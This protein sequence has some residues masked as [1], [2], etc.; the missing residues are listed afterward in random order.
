MK[1]KLELE[2]DN[3]AFD[4]DPDAEVWDILRKASEKVLH[5]GIPVDAKYRLMDSN[6]NTVGFMTAEE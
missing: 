1:L 3:A 2:M 4:D 5:H 6:G